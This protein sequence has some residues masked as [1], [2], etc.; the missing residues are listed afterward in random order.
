MTVGGVEYYH[1]TSE[2]GNVILFSLTGEPV[3]IYDKETDTV[4]EA[5]FDC[6]S[7]CE[8]DCDE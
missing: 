2:D 5:E 4:Q 8:S 1:S 6:D 7:D 3:G